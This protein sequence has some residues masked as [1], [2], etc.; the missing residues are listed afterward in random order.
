MTY[1]NR[2]NKIRKK[3]V[4]VPASHVEE[5]GALVQSHPVFSELYI[6]TR[7]ALY[8]RYATKNKLNPSHV[9][10]SEIGSVGVGKEV[11]LK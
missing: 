9:A 6:F 8:I 10:G 4:S 5:H 11:D 7:V 2:D 1:N 3:E